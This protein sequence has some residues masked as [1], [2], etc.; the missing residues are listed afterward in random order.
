[1]GKLKRILT[2]LFNTGFKVG[3]VVVFVS[4]FMMYLPLIQ[5]KI[6]PFL[7]YIG[8]WEALNSSPEWARVL[9]IGF[10]LI[11]AAIVISILRGWVDEMVNIL[12]SDNKGQI[13]RS[14]L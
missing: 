12:F 13:P 9:I 8:F 7:E 14:S 1:M 4:V 5:V 11:G 2:F 10:T 3:I 6:S